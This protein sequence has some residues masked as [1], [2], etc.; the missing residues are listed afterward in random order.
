MKFI[1]YTLAVIGG[2]ALIRY[3]RNKMAQNRGVTAPAKTK[4]A[5]APQLRGQEQIIITVPTIE[6]DIGMIDWVGGQG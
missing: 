6:G 4:T 2:I 5:P 3:G 1:T